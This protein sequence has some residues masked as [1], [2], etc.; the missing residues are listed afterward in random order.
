LPPDRSEGHPGRRQHSWASGAVRS[1]HRAL[2]SEIAGSNPVWP[3]RIDPRRTRHGRGLESRPGNQAAVAQPARAPAR[4]AG[5]RR[6]DSVRWLSC[7][8]GTSPS[9]PPRSAP[10]RDGLTAGHR[11][12]DPGGGGSSPPL[13]A[14]QAVQGTLGPPCHGEGRVGGAMERS[15]SGYGAA[16]LMRWGFAPRGFESRSLRHPGVAQ[17]VRAPPR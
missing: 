3:T 7:G 6:F 16:L 14:R 2:N 12:L 1:A 5:G 17:Q 4:Y 10:F 15:P 13:G 9:R 8:R 11:I